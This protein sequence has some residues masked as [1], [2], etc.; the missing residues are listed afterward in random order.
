MEVIVNGENKLNEAAK[1]Y[2]PITLNFRRDV[3]KV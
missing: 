3:G 2:A 1:R